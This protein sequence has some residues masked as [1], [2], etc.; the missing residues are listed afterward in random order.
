MRR[1]AIAIIITVTIFMA[2]PLLGLV[3]SPWTLLTEYWEFYLIFIIIPY[4][5]AGLLLFLSK[6]SRT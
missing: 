5:V 2:I 1:L 6:K 3:E 4:A